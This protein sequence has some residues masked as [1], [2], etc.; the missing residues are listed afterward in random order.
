MIGRTK[1]TD[2]VTMPHIYN[3]QSTSSDVGESLYYRAYQ[4]RAIPPP[5]PPAAAYCPTMR[6][7]TAVGDT[8]ALC[9]PSSPIQTAVGLR[10]H[11]SLTGLPQSCDVV[12]CAS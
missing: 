2:D 9:G 6:P 1:F 7:I 8:A 11:P 3:G 10:H 5:P 12:R 4:S